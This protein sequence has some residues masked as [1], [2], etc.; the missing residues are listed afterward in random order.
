M[1]FVSTGGHFDQIASFYTYNV[2]DILPFIIHSRH[3]LAIANYGDIDGN[4]NINSQILIYDNH[5]QTFEHFQYVKTEGAR[6]WEYFGFG[7]SRHREHFLAVINNPEDSKFSNS[8]PA[9]NFV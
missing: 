4:V 2:T 5:L 8:A 3:Y 7:D 1:F 9:T 6:D